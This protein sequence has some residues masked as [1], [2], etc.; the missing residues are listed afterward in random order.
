MLQ[1]TVTKKRTHISSHLMHLLEIYSSNLQ[2]RRCKKQSV[3]H[4]CIC[5]Y[6]EG[7]EKRQ[8]DKQ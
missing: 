2:Q 6:E 1:W 3:Q 4:E 5:F 7:E 8:E